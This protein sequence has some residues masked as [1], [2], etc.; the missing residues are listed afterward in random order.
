MIQVERALDDSS[1]VGLARDVEL[2]AAG[3]GLARELRPETGSLCEPR[4]F[5]GLDAWLKSEPIAPRVARRLAL[6]A[7][8]LGRPY[9]RLAEF[10]N[11]LWLRE[12]GFGAPEPLL[13]LIG[14][15]EG[16]AR[17]Q[18]LVT[19][20]VPQARDLRSVLEAR[21]GSLHELLE[22]LGARIAALHAAGFVH[23]D[24]HPR[25]LLV[26]EAPSGPEVLFLDAWRGG[27]RRQLRG[28]AYD[29]ACLFLHL[30][31]WLD[32]REQGQLF[33]AYVRGREAQSAPIRP[34]TFARRVARGR[35]GLIRRARTEPGRLRGL[36]LPDPTWSLPIP[37]P[38]IV[39]AVLAPLSKDSHPPAS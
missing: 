11:L 36:P 33:E 10:E 29:L 21:E 38:R 30:P 7:R 20:A 1:L 3:E 2:A 9:P 37:D 31:E 8:L 16:R 4:H 28:A 19:R 34:R 13:A 12:H 24:L 18:L 17:W 26:R 32:E 22:V 25:N 27:A 15:R 6:R 35:R 23:R 14:L 39:R 5:A